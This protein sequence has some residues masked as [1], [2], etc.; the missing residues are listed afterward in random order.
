MF[1][2]DIYSILSEPLA[3][4]EKISYQWTT[5]S[6]L[7]FTWENAEMIRYLDFGLFMPTVMLSYLIFPTGIKLSKKIRLWL[8]VIGITVVIAVVTVG[9]L[10][11]SDV[12]RLDTQGSLQSRYLIVPWVLFGLSGNVWSYLVKKIPVL[13]TVDI[14]K[15]LEKY[16]LLTSLFFF[17]GGAVGQIVRYYTVFN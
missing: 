4:F 8:L 13:D 5:F 2:E 7:L 1:L 17:V 10:M 12:D 16:V 11:W 3:L 6:W 14:D 9:Y 15:T